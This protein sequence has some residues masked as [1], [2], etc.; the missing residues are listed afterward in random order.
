MPR[1]RG[2]Q[3]PPPPPPPPPAPPP[4]VHPGDFNP[5]TTPFQGAHTSLEGPPN[6]FRGPIDRRPPHFVSDPPPPFILPPLV[7]PTSQQRG[8]GGQHSPAQDNREESIR[9]RRQEA[10]REAALLQQ[11]QQMIQSF[12]NPQ[13]LSYGRNSSAMNQGMGQQSRQGSTPLSAP[14]RPPMP[15]SSNQ[16]SEP[17]HLEAAQSGAAQGRRHRHPHH[18][19]LRPRR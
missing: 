9:R 15:G 19:P 6:P 5:W 3:P 8:Q 1:R 14:Q 11:R 7:Q 16:Q 18:R 4:Y 13:D 2:T 10:E 12:P 17:S